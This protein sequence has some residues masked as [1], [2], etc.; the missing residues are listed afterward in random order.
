MKRYVAYLGSTAQNYIVSTGLGDWY[1][2]GPNPPWGSQLTPVALTATAFYYYDNWILARTAQ[3]L[4]KPGEASQFDA[5]ATQI[6]V[7]FNRKFYNPQTGQY[8]TGSQCANS[9]PLVM[10]IVEST[11]R[12]AVLDAIVADVRSRGNALT[13][14]DVG[15]RYLLRALAEGGRSDVIFNMNNQSERPGYGY[16]LKKGATSLTEKW[17]AAV[18]NFGSQNHFMLGQIIEW[19]YHDLAGIGLDPAGPGFKK[20]II[21]PQPVGNLKWVKASYDSIRGRIS[22][23]W[24]WSNGR[25]AL[26]VM[27]PANTT[28]TVFVPSMPGTKVSEGKVAAEDSLGVS[29]LRREDDRMVYAIDCGEYEFCSLYESVEQ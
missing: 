28:A 27:I 9:I 14:G 15:Y 22:S 6:R 5:L 11:N 20:I 3:L 16:Q 17:D 25:F 23:E 13:A 12:A 29:F 1:D 19:F 18:G 21:R 24:K 26:K 2:I 4:G 10:D 7:A 8:A